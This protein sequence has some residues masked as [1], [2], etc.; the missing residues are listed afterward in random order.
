MAARKPYSRTIADDTPMIPEM[1]AD[2]VFDEVAMFRGRGLPDEAK[3]S[4]L[5]CDQANRSYQHNET[6]RKKVRGRGNSGLE[7][8]RMFMRHWLSSD[9]KRLHPEIFKEL[10]KS[11]HVGK[12][13]RS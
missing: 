4:Q 7:Y 11:F 5:I 3:L 8:L 1:V 6:F 2:S 10:P 13:L 9:L 12:S